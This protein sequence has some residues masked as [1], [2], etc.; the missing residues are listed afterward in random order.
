MLLLYDGLP[1]LL[2]EARQHMLFADQDGTLHQHAVGGQQ[3]DLLVLAGGEGEQWYRGTRVANPNTHGTGCTLSSA[4]ASN[5]AKGFTLDESVERGKAYISGAL[6]AMLDLGAGSGPMNH[7][8][9]ISGE[10]A[11]EA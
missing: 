6:S 5:L 3:S 4:I 8:F 2:P 10:F 11:K 7:A 1:L 9:D